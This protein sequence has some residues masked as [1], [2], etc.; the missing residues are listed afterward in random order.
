[1]RTRPIAREGAKQ[2]EE[3]PGAVCPWRR[4][5]R[6]FVLPCP[7]ELRD[8]GTAKG[9]LVGEE[10]L[11][12]TIL[13]SYITP[14]LNP[15][16]QPSENYSRC[17]AWSGPAQKPRARS[18]RAEECACVRGASRAGPRGD[19]SAKKTDNTATDGELVSD[20]FLSR[21]GVWSIMASWVCACGDNAPG[22]EGL[23]AQNG[24]PI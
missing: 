13:T 15:S 3:G 18:P 21:G 9:L 22:L 11:K 14:A 6:W 8:L 4:G 5:R 1:M 10:S 16:C 17:G 12:T 19:A 24:I 2:E 23:H 20:A 7:R